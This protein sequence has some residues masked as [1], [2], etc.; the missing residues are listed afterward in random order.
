LGTYQQNIVSVF[1]KVGDAK[2][3]GD[4]KTAAVRIAPPLLENQILI[5]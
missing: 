4:G 5:I 1:S 2:G 3:F